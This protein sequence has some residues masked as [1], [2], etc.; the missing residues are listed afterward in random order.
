MLG[1]IESKM[2][3]ILIV[4]WIIMGLWYANGLLR[5]FED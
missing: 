4:K 1:D 5:A 2:V 3:D